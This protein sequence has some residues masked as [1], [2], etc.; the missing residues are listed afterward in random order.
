MRLRGWE[1]VFKVCSRYSLGAKSGQMTDARLSDPVRR[2][3]TLERADHTPLAPGFRP[4]H[5]RTSQPLDVIEL[6]SEA[7]QRVAG[8]RVKAGRNQN[9]IRNEAG[10]GLVDPSLECGD[11]L[12]RRKTRAH[13]EIPDAA[14]GTAVVRRT[15]TRIPGPLV[16]RHE[17]NVRLIL[18]ERLSPVAV[19]HV[20]VDDEYP[21]QSVASARVVRGECNVAEQAKSHR[22]VSDCVMSRGA[23]G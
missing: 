3:A 16:H 4:R 20:P 12:I 8:E 10:R 5:D 7:A 11:V 6:Q 22:A 13:R 2:I 14:A 9:E 15:G 1:G 21:L 17:A 18:D 23:D 19:V